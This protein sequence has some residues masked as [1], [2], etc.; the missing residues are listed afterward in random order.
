[1]SENK[2]TVT[3]RGFLK[4]IGA[5]GGLS[6][7][8]GQGFV[9][10]ALAE[11]TSAGVP[12]KW[13]YET[14]VLVIGFGGAGATTAIAAAD[15]GA[16]VILIEK[17]EEATHY[18][19]TRMSGGIFHSPD[20]DGDPAALK[21]YL[22]AA[23][24]GENLPWKLEGEQ[25]V[26]SDAIATKFA[27]Y[28]VENIDFLAA[29]DPDVKF[30]ARGG[31]AFPSF[32]GAE[33]SKYKTYFATYTGQGAYAA[34]TKDLP[35]EQKAN[36]EAF[37]NAL[38]IGVDARDA[39]T[40]MYEAPAKSLVVADGEVIGA[41][42]EQGGQD[43]AIK[44]K[45]AVVL[46]SGGYEYNKEMREAFLEGPGVEG[47]AFYGTTANTGDGIKMAVALGAQLAKVGKAASRI[48]TAVP[49][50]H[51]DMKIGLIT[52]AVGQPNEIVVDSYG[53]RYAAET[54]VTDDP[55]RYFFYKEAVKFDITKLE[56]P[57]V[58]SWLIFDETLRT[59]MPITYLGISTVGYGFVPWTEDNLD[60]VERGWILKADTLEELA[61]KIKEHPE[62]REKMDAANLTAAV[63]K[64]N[65]MCAAGEDTE[66]ARRP[67]TMAPVETAPFYAAP[68]YPGGPNTKGG[69][70][71]DA[72]RH[73]LDWNNQPIPRL[74]T[75]GEIS[76]T[77]KFVYQGG[78]N[79]TECLV[80]GRIAGENA[81]AEAP[82]A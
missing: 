17:Q 38:K 48:I 19:N 36:G 35:K 56:Y 25:P 11:G 29:C 24:S 62:N 14:D 15:A 2:K 64:Y 33:E 28:E 60:A 50:R 73:V 1:M 72:E 30:G 80:C 51:N 65:E 57:R 22:L 61:E 34:S 54:M 59:S 12:E 27:Q 13:D 66:F 43:I 49:I 53:N 67:E 47:W 79:L 70:M 6:V 5:A 42:A 8:A 77:W 52:P 4:G 41:I 3:R 21:Q 68:L 63:E 37:F 23:F 69:I 20:K 82:L 18:S 44:A 76:S 26:V 10:S 58:P 31:A 45:K 55:S 9:G 75:A 16:Q 39:I 81:A 46:T 32:P 40:V 78:G 71:A 7:L 74:Y